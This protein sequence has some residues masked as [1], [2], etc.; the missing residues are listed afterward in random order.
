MYKGERLLQFMKY[1]SIVSRHCH[2]YV[3]QIFVFPFWEFGL[4]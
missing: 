3:K 2:K 1:S 4:S